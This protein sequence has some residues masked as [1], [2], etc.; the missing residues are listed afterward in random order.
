VGRT[1]FKNFSFASIRS[2]KIN[3]V[4]LWSETVKVKLPDSKKKN[5]SLKDVEI[6]SCL[7]T[8]Y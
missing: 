8:L 1:N 6:T 4:Y 2:V 7:L 3:P 5:H